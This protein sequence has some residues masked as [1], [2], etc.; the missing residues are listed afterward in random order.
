[1]RTTETIIEEDPL[2]HDGESSG[3]SAKEDDGPTPST[4]ATRRLR[5]RPSPAEAVQEK[6]AAPGPPREKQHQSVRRTE[7]YADP[8]GLDERNA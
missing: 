4:G 7:S 6:E 1:M 5:F 8:E 3:S 2:P